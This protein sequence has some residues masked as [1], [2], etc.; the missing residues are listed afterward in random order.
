M[1][2]YATIFCALLFLPLV[3]F[4]Q[5]VTTAGMNGTVLDESGE[6]LPGAN[7]LV[8]HVPSGTEYGA[9]TNNSGSFH[10]RNIRVGGPYRIRVTF[11]GYEP[12]VEEGVQLALGETYKFKAQMKPGSTQLGEVEVVAAGDVFNRNKTGVGKNVGTADIEDAP[13][14][15][16]S[17]ADYSR[18]TPQAYV[19]N[20]D[21]DGA[22]ISIAGQNNRFNSIFIDGAINN[23][24]FGLSAQGTNGGQTGASP[25]SMDAI[26]QFQINLSPFDVTQGGFTGGAI[27]AITRSGTNKYEGSVYWFNRN[28]SLA[29]ETPIGLANFNDI[30]REPLPEFKN[31]RFGFR[32]GGPIIEDKLFF[33]ANLEMLRSQS[34]QPFLGINS[35]QGDADIST[36]EEISTTLQ[37]EFSYNAGTFRDKNSSLDSDKALVKLNWN[38][39]QQ[40]KLMFRHSYTKSDNIDRYQ[41]GTGTINYSNNSEVFPNTTH[42]S[43]LELTS[44]FG[45]D[46]ANKLTIG[47]TDVLD[48]RDYDGEAFPTVTIFDGDGEIS[49]GNEPF[50]TSNLLDQE[51][52][53]ITNDF[54]IF[55]GDHTITIGTHNE[56]YDMANQ[57]IPFNNGWYFYYSPQDFLQS[58]RSVNDPNI[59]PAAPALYLRGVSL[60]GGQNVIGDEAKN[61]GAFNAY[62]LGLYVQ[63]EWQLNDQLRLTGGLRFDVPKITTD[64][65]Y[66]DD[67]F[68]T[69]IPELQALGKDLKGARPGE[70]PAA[71]LYVSPR[72]GFNWD[73]FGDG[74]TQLRGG[75][76]VF[77]GRVPFVWPGGM[78][79]NN[80][81]NTG[82]IEAG[83]FEDQTTLSNGNTIPFRPNPT[84]GLTLEDFGRSADQVIPS[85]RLEMFA[86]DFRYPTVFRTS[87][88]VDQRLPYGIIGSLE[89]QYTKTMNNIVIENV[90]LKAQNDRL[91]G[92]DNRPFY[93]YSDRYVDSRY[94]N[95]HVVSNTSKGHTYDITAQL[96]KNFGNGFRTNLSYTYGDAYVIN[97]GTSSQINSLWQYQE[98][99]NG[100]NNLALSRSDFSLGHRV[101]ASLVYRKEFLDNLATTISL[102]FEGNSGRPTSFVIDQ[103]TNMVNEGGDDASLI[104][105]PEDAS[106]LAWE[107]TPTEQ[108]AQAEAFDQFIESSDYLS[109]RR[110]Q[111]AERNASRAPFESIIDLKVEQE[112][113]AD[114]MNR[115]QKLEF[116]LDIFNFTSLLGDLVDTSWGNRYSI[117]NGVYEPIEFTG[118]RDEANGDYTPVYSLNYGSDQIQ[119]VDDM[120]KANI[121]DF[122]TYSS[123]WL[124]QFGVRYTF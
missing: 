16:R 55:A 119:T 112:I 58:V 57:F 104:Y 68:S 111:Y 123:R 3:V 108:Q 23:D 6:S 75:A 84:E 83:D 45:N 32:V 70:T 37:D 81:A 49:L 90:N 97:E 40:H 100:A 101:T 2:R 63:D 61:I 118:F 105:I 114:L 89:F 28:E 77:L 25:I 47:Y 88:G 19:V 85:G 41:S 50:S 24:V 69:T 15:G 80:G 64:P 42:S 122:G 21:D 65:R 14:V 66:A 9:A 94:S 120:Y 116:T 51:I 102:F 74:N 46:M 10:I 60:V 82:T 124:M 43:A 59:D 18:L 98:H 107:G 76:G 27:N 67:V 93:N 20:S 103:S 109:S 110:G 11:V 31:N 121:Q 113:F 115:R 87:L 35:Y 56:F 34:P 44:S 30:N 62:Q 91:D 72:F 22:A 99:V 79:L 17:L 73:A 71:Q 39:N 5:G 92:P 8:L 117:G 13:T 36:L 52:L 78:F 29:G 86:E 53:T 1:K 106:N 48:D 95:I 38:I 4:G 33:F 12:Y 7:V 26:E 96:R 54:N